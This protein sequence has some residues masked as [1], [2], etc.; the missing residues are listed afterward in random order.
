ML[1][2][3]DPMGMKQKARVV[4]TEQTV[5]S[6][7]GTIELQDS[8][9]QVSIEG[10]DRAEVELTVIKTT[11]RKYSELEMP[12]AMTE[13]D[14]ILIGT[15]RPSDNHLV[16][17][18]TFPDRNLTRPLRGKSNVDLEYH[19]RAP[20][21]TRLIVK[22]DTGEVNVSDIVGDMRVTARIGDI[23][24]HL[25]PEA[26]Y[27]VNAKA[28][29]G[30]VCSEWGNSMRDHLIGAQAIEHADPPAYEL[31]LRVGIGDISVHKLVEEA[32]TTVD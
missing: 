9:G 24:L 18:T 15:E 14:R 2:T 21:Q 6:S 22:H 30:E 12:H 20:R 27:A 7:G 10:W 29:V 31:Y 1:A 16:I 13:L 32:E 3:T 8:F 23:S 26:R 17:T 5:F 11:Q 4:D 19:I 25:S 28:K